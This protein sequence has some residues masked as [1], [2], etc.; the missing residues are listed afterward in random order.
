METAVKEGLTTSG[1]VMSMLKENTGRHALDSGGA[2]GRHWERNQHI[3]FEKTPA[4]LLQFDDRIEYTRSVYHHIVNYLEYDRLLTETFHELYLNEFDPDEEM[5]WL[6]LMENF[7]GWLADNSQ[8][9]IV[10]PASVEHLGGGNSAN[11]ESNLSQTLQW[12]AFI[13]DGDEYL[14]L[15]IHGGCDIRGGYTAP[16]I[17]KVR[18]EGFYLF[19]DGYI[20]C[21]HC[22]ASWYTDDDYHWYPNGK[23]KELQDYEIKEIYDYDL[24]TPGLIDW[25]ETAFIDPNQTSLVP[26]HKISVPDEL[27]E[28]LEKWDWDETARFKFAGRRIEVSLDSI[29]VNG[30]EYQVVFKNKGIIVEDDGDGICPVC[31][32]GLLCA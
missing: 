29:W 16:K 17:F 13:M 31:G 18:D 22:D 26:V 9:I 8:R 30:R 10:Y 23:F 6:Q 14:L 19:A 32:I 27:R 21:D 5:G 25:L 7:P 2:Y 24:R 1:A 4:I 12:E 11:G 28:I 20:T 15:Q 3:D